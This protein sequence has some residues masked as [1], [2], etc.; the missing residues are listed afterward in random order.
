MCLG[1]AQ[2]FPHFKKVNSRMHNM[3]QNDPDNAAHVD[4]LKHFVNF[5]TVL[6]NF[7]INLLCSL[8]R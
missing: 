8:M 2:I 3:G 4:C 5:F 7:V 1:V 6:L